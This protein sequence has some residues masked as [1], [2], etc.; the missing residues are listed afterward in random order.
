M[1]Y[2]SE[3]TKKIFEDYK[4]TLRT[5]KAKSEYFYVI[6][7]FCEYTQKDYLDCGYS[8]FKAF[9]DMLDTSVASGRYSFKTICFKHSVL[10]MFSTYID[11]YSDTYGIKDF[12]NYMIKI[13]KPVA[14]VAVKP[15]SIPTAE[16]LDKIYEAAKDDPLMYAIIALVN[17]CALTTAQ[18]STLRKSNFIIDSNQNVGMVFPYEFG[19]NRYLKITDDVVKILNSYITTRND[20]SDYFFIGKG[21]KPLS[22]RTLQGRTSRLME[23]AFGPNGKSFTLQDLR[24]LSV[25]LM[26]KGG[27][28]EETVAEYIG[29]GAKWIQ[30]Y[31]RAVEEFNKAPCDYINISVSGL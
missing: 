20:E 23:K 17:K 3:T 21:G 8:D 25:V 26:L 5:E 1:G 31:G 13:P 7:S 16:E 14:S 18:L 10:H 6:N 30:R 4:E 11:A 2:L 27:A 9:C 19:S 12:R 24:N 29:I 22:H 28:A 15:A